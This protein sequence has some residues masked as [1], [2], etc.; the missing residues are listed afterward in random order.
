MRQ[1]YS[2]YN[3]PS[4]FAPSTLQ[5]AAWISPNVRASLPTRLV[6]M[7]GLAATCERLH[8]RVDAVAENDGEHCP[9]FRS[10]EVQDGTSCG[11]KQRQGHAD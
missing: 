5:R 2:Y 1:T 10:N 11:A 6:R 8:G 9:K 7:V 3:V 4:K